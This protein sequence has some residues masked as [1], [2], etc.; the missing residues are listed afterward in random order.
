[1]PVYEYRCTKCQTEFEIL[2]FN[3]KKN[4]VV[5]PKC[6]SNLVK[7]LISNLGFLR[8][9]LQTISKPETKKD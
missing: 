2:K 6:G 8:H 9:P 7:K 3:N 4:K 5:C 1:M